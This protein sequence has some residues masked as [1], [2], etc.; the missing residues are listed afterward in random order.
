MHFQD[1][2][3]EA[4]FRTEARSWLEKNAPPRRDMGGSDAAKIKDLQ[5]ALREGREWMAKKASAGWACLHWAPEYGGR[6]ASPIERII[7]TQEEAR[8]VDADAIFTI[9]QNTCAPVLMQ[10]MSEE[11]RRRFLPKIANGDEIWCQL[12]SEPG[13][14][15][16]LAGLRTRSVRDG[17]D[18]IVNGQKVWTSGAHYS[19]YAILLTRSDPT[20]PKHKGLT[21]FFVDM[22]SPGIEIRPIRQMSGTSNFNEVFLTDVRIPDAQRL[23]EVGKGWSVAMTTLTNERFEAGEA[24]GVDFDD[25]FNFVASLGT[26]DDAPIKNNAVRAKLA[27][28]YCESR[29][30]Q[31]FAYRMLSKLSAGEKLGAEVSVIT[32]TR[33]KRTQ[34]IASFAMDLME[35]GGI[36]D[37]P[38]MLAD[39]ERFL[40]SYFWAPGSRIAGGT[41]EILRNIIAEQVLGMPADIRVDKTAP[42]NELKNGKK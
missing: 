1:S 28:W 31:Y 25:L 24:R 16:D 32:A 10:H 15:S 2:P 17:D 40:E 14:G 30:T 21:F 11:Q 41:D 35:Q 12:F 38:A 9:G 23:G 39:K 6:G 27:E 3:Q 37:E 42:F 36:L 20:V 29:G 26:D 18:W 5:R 8:F 7:W 34:D 13:A 33:P 4:A 22:R 19:D